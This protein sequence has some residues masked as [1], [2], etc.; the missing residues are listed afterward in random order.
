LANG[1]GIND[2]GVDGY[3]VGGNSRTVSEQMARQH[4]F[5]GSGS[6]LRYPSILGWTDVDCFVFGEIGMVSD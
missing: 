1:L 3:F 6:N 2:F 4:H 5:H